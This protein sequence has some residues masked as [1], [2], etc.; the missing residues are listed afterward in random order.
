MDVKMEESYEAAKVLLEMSGVCDPAFSENYVML[1]PEFYK[2]DKTNYTCQ[3]FDKVYKLGGKIGEG[4]FGVVRRATNLLTGKEVAIKIQKQSKKNTSDLFKKEISNLR[5]LIKECQFFVCIEG[6]G[7]YRGKLFVSMENINGIS[8][9]E[10]KK[11]TDLNFRQRQFSRIAYQLITNVKTLHEKGMAHTDIKPDNIMIELR[12]GIVRLVDFGL[13]CDKES[14]CHTGGTRLYMPNKPIKS[15][16]EERVK[17]D[18]YSLAITL[19]EI[20]D[21]KNNTTK[22]KDPLEYLSKLQLP[23]II[24]NTIRKLLS[25]SKLI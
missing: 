5:K 17:S 3:D 8:L 1:N 2:N 19:L 14:K 23:E 4:Q 11:M 13:G 21:T 16:F 10:Y 9:T 12:T 20:M 15:T 25:E 24:D 22:I 6:W 18:W 7:L